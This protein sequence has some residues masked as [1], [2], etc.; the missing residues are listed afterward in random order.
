M[1]WRCSR[2][3]SGAGDAAAV[4]MCWFQHAREQ[5]TC[6][7]KQAGMVACVYRNLIAAMFLRA[8]ETVPDECQED[9]Y[10]FMI[11]RGK[12]INAN[13]PLGEQQAELQLPE[14]GEMAAAAAAAAL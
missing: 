13:I 9:V 2:A 1:C 12:N 11:T 5:H 14:L 4:I 7:K 3:T 8:A 10:Q 6:R